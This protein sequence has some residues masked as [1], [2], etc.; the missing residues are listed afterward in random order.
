[1]IDAAKIQGGHF[2]AK[3]RNIQRREPASNSRADKPVPVNAGVT[4]FA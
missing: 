4:D 2:I 3:T 1:M